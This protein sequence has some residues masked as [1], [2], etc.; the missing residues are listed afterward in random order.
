MKNKKLGLFFTRNISL[1][2]W[3][4]KGLL[5]REKL[6]YEEHLKKG[7]LSEVTWFTY[8]HNDSDIAKELKEKGRLHPSINIVPMP[9][10]F[11]ESKLGILFYSFLMSFINFER[12]SK[13]DFFKTNQMDGAWA[14]VIAKLL[15][16]KPLIIRTGFTLS[17][18]LLKK[19]R[20]NFSIISLV[21]KYIYQFSDLAYVSSEADKGYL[22]ERYGLSTN[23][24]K[25]LH[26]YIDTELFFD[27]GLERKDAYVFI[28]RL[29]SQKNLFALLEAFKGSSHKLDLYGDGDQKEELE[30][31]NNSENISFKGRI[32]NDQVAEVL[33]SYKY[34]ILPSF[35][36]G[37][38][39][40]LLEG[41][42]SGCLALGTPVVGINE[43]IRHNH[44][45]LLAAS[46]SAE[47]IKALIKLSRASDASGLI[48]ASKNTIDKEFSLKGISN[49]EA[50]FWATL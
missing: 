1:E 13:L 34:Y 45:G 15:T 48:E 29:N 10:Y 11:P 5:D 20:L 25:V 8:G 28:G 43:V 17:L 14:A 49:L 32:S 27:K 6:I 21:E 19:S 36:E 33:N 12:L 38:P 26:N 16:Q 24:I 40:T 50:Q 37:M 4:D 18:F 22:T 7:T 3:R 23:H 46:T 31:S 41:M 30:N 2:V 35:Y 9:K 44:N 39:K 47:D 42:A